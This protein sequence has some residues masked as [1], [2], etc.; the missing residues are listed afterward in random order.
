MTTPTTKEALQ[1]AWRFLKIFAVSFISLAVFAV[2]GIAAIWVLAWIFDLI[3]LYTQLD[4]G[5]AAT[6]L[7]VLVIAALAS[8]LNEHN[9][10]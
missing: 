2:I 6:T 9:Q 1:S 5:F 3:H 8:A 4:T 7:I 10:G